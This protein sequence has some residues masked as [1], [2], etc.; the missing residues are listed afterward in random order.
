MAAGIL[1][2]KIMKRRR[3]DQAEANAE[4]ER[5]LKAPL[6]NAGAEQDPLVEKYQEQNPGI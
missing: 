3:A 5:I 4:A 2:L 6:E 1:L